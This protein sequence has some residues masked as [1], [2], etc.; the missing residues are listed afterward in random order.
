[1]ERWVGWGGEASSCIREVESD[2]DNLL[3]VWVINQGWL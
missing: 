2:L 3:D 1:M